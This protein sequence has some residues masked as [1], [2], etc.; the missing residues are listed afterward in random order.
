MVGNLP[1]VE[2]N[3]ASAA[4]RGVPGGKGAPVGSK[5]DPV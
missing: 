3:L 4:P 2:D 5:A 1:P